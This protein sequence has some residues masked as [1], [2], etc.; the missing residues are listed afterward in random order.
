MKKQFGYIRKFLGFFTSVFTCVIIASSIFILCYS[1][2]YLPLK[3]IVQAG[4]IAALSSGLNFIYTSEK[5]ISKKSMFIR[6]TVHFGLL[7]SAV[8]G[9]ALYF[10][11]FSFK[12]G[13]MLTFFGLFIAVYLI[14]WSANFMWD[15][16]DEKMMNLKLK[17]YK[18]KL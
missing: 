1:N 8:T 3:L 2:P 4:I 18:T 15:I 9:C 12:N 7:L 5:P 17:E 16:I 14:I 11:W 10:K 6:T 13:V